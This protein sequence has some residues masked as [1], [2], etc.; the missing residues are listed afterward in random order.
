MG[1]PR[2]VRECWVDGGWWMD[3]QSQDDV[4]GQGTKLTDWANLGDQG[5]LSMP[6]LG[7]ANGLHPTPLWDVAKMETFSPTVRSA[8]PPPS[9]DLDVR[10]WWVEEKKI[11]KVGFAVQAPT[12]S[13]VVSIRSNPRPGADMSAGTCHP[14]LII[15]GYGTR[16]V[17]AGL[18][19]SQS[20]SRPQPKETRSCRAKHFS[21]LHRKACLFL[22]WTEAH[23]FFFILRSSYVLCLLQTIYS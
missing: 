23:V 2:M 13:T 10:G 14:C 21:G 17:S 9:T 20:Q 1:K 12:G 16:A 6:R 18:S 5:N 19:P 4:D 3:D 8:L 11:K 22:F 15:V 7:P